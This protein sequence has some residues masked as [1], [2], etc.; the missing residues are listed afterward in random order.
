MA[1]MSDKLRQYPVAVE[2][3]EGSSTH[4]RH[5]HKVDHRDTSALSRSDAV[6]RQGADKF[7]CQKRRLASCWHGSSRTLHWC[8]ISIFGLESS[9][10]Q[11]KSRKTRDARR[12]YSHS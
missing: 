1:D 8:D 9:K 4:R 7:N 2:A 10:T 3:I 11:A 5:Y 6:E 12:E